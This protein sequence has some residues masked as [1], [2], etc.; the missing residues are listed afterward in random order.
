MISVSGCYL[1]ICRLTHRRIKKRDLRRV[2]GELGSRI[3]LIKVL[4]VTH[5]LLLQLLDSPLECRSDRLIPPFFGVIG[6]VCNWQVGESV[7]CLLHHHRLGI[8]ALCLKMLYKPIGMLNRDE[9]VLYCA[10]DSGRWETW[11]D[12][13]QNRGLWWIRLIVSDNKRVECFALKRLAH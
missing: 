3:I 8:N 11:R 7:L 10:K 2:A 5:R 4:E 1:S 13:A 12:G 6:K 9:R